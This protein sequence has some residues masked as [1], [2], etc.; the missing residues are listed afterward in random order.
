MSAHQEEVT[1]EV[2]ADATEGN[3][4]NNVKFSP[5]L[6]DEKIKAS[7][8]PLHSQISALTETMDRL[9]QNNSARK[10]TTASTREP[11]SRPE[12]PFAEASG[13]SRFLTVVPVTTAGHSPDIEVVYLSS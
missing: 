13:T 12:S 2:E 10:F 11:Q 8:E 3:E 4:E 9:I 1:G 5:D 7:L 6:V